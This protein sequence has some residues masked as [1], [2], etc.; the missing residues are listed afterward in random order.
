EEE[1]GNEALTPSENQISQPLLSLDDFPVLSARRFKSP[2]S[3]N[4][5][6][7]KHIDPPDKGGIIT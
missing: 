5:R 4:E 3:H 7:L 2:K 1:K 6:G